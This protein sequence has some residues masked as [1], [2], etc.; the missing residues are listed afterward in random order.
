[1]A[2][3][4]GADDTAMTELLLAAHRGDK[5]GLDLLMPRLYDELRRLAASFLRHERANHTLQPTA[6]VNE[7]YLRLIDQR[8]VNWQNRAQ[9]F[10]LAAQMMRRILVN[11]AEAKL[12][13]KRGGGA[14]HVTL[15]AAHAI[16]EDRTVEILAVNQALDKLAAFDPLKAQ[17]VEMRMFAGLTTEELASVVG[18]STATVEREWRIARA[19]LHDE[20]HG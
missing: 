2:G 11:H 1:M 15:D 12:A 10:G 3:P 13:S 14:P 5:G 8:A 17:L 19:W 9:F 7:A 6:L 4:P 20:L 18:K 16:G